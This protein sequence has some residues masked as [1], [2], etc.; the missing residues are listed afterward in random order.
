MV[1]KQSFRLFELNAAE[2][3]SKQS[4]FMHFHYLCV[5]DFFCM[6]M[7]KGV[8]HLLAP[9]WVL[10]A[11]VGWFKHATMKN[12][13]WIV[14]N[15]YRLTFRARK[16]Y[17][18]AVIF[19]LLSPKSLVVH[20]KWILFVLSILFTL[21]VTTRNCLSLRKEWR[22][23]HRM[24]VNES[25]SCLIINEGIMSV[26][27]ITMD[28]WGEGQSMRILSVVKKILFYNKRQACSDCH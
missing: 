12:F 13:W 26:I 2:F 5:E 11:Y 19:V 24:D 4:G 27:L 3:C 25:L 8:S 23:N 28:V 7:L 16:S 14:S 17:I 10:Y 21:M 20:N 1:K 18:V 9:W 6:P 22:A 15:K